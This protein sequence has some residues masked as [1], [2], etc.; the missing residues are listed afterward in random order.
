MNQ[1]EKELA[2]SYEL[3]AIRRTA[4]SAPLL[5]LQEFNETNYPNQKQLEFMVRTAHSYSDIL[6]LPLVS[7]IT[8][9]LD[10]GD[11]FSRYLDFLE[12]VLDTIDTYNKKPLMGV[13]PMKIP[14]IRIEDLVRFYCGRGIRAFCLD[15]AGSKPD[16]ARQSVEQVSFSL[17]KE[18]VLNESFVHAINVSPGR[19]RVATPVSPCHSILAYGYGADSFGDL[20]RTRMRIET[21]PIPH[22]PT[23]VRLFSRDD[24][25]DHQINAESD[26][27][28]MEPDK[29]G[30][31]LRKCVRNKQLTKLFNAEQHSIE[32][33]V[34]PT[35]IDAGRDQPGLTQYLSGKAYVKKTQLKRM[36][37][38]RSNL[39]QSRLS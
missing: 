28:R 22:R 29:T 7:R 21:P 37:G 31:S 5:L 25:G 6:I 35:F 23:P 14:F 36:R 32:A 26:L 2:L 34:L 12:V 8:D 10:A 19:P 17:A 16:T 1:K 15:F 33:S 4:G 9:K 24:Y 30:I 11:G 18:N 38:L 20:H 3:N 13:I 27:K 39:K